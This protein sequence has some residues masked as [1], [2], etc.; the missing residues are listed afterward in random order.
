MLRSE[1]DK[2]SLIA[3][4][5]TNLSIDIQT[6]DLGDDIVSF[7]SG[8]LKLIPSTTINWSVVSPNKLKAN[9]VF[10][11][12]AAHKHY[13][14]QTP[15]HENLISPDYINFKVNSVVTPFIEGSLRVYV[16][17]VRLTTTGIY[18]PGAI[19]TD[20]WT[21]LSF[22]PDAVDGT[23]ALSTALSSEDIIRIDYDISF[24]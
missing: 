5:A 16:N 2:L 23:F 15:V 6:D 4:E 19:P 11:A 21:L 9:M 20:S 12:E 24:I 18:V 1:S 17:G 7:A 3:D 8:I 14:D 10:P 22:T 13:Y